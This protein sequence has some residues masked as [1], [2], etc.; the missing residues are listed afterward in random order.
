MAEQHGFGPLDAE[1]LAAY[2]DGRLAPEERAR[3][4]S[5]LA[6]SS[7]AYEWLV[8]V[9]RAAAH[10]EAERADEGSGNAARPGADVP[11]ATGGPAGPS[12]AGTAAGP[13][14]HPPRVLPFYRR[15]GF[16]AGV[17]TTMAAAAALVVALDVTPDWWRR[18]VTPERSGL[19]VLVAAVGDERYVES[20]FTGG[21]KYGPLRSATRGSGDG[22]TPNLALMAAAGEL[23]QESRSRPTVEN[24]HAW[25]VAQVLLGYYDEGLRALNL[26]LADAPESPAVMADLAAAHIARGDALSTARDYPRALAAAEQALARRPDLAEAAFNRALALERLGL[27]REALEAWQQVIAISTGAGD[28]EEWTAEARRRVDT[29]KRSLDEARSLPGF[30]SLEDTTEAS[31]RTLAEED[32]QRAREFVEIHVLSAWGHALLERRRA[33]ADRFLALARV[34]A[35]PIGA[36]GN[37]S[38]PEAVALIEGS[39]PAARAT[40]ARAHVRFGESLRLY[41]GEQAG[42]TLDGF[43]ESRLLFERA[44]SPYRSW[45]AVQEMAVYYLRGGLAAATGAADRLRASPD[46]AKYPEIDARLS[47]AQGLFAANGGRLQEALQH[48]EHAAGLY[49]TLGERENGVFLKTLTAE[50]LDFVGDEGQAWRYRVEA[51]REALPARNPRRPHTTWVNAAIAAIRQGTPEVA[52]HLQDEAVALAEVHRQP[53]LTFEAHLYRAR[54]GVAAGNTAMALEDLRIA[55][56]LLPSLPAAF[57]PRMKTEVLVTHGTLPGQTADTLSRTAAAWLAE[58]GAVVRVPTLMQSAAAAR[59]ARGDM[60]G[61]LQD[62]SQAIDAATDQVPRAVESLRWAYADT[63]WP[64]FRQAAILRMATGDIT[65]ALGV[66]EMG[67]MRLPGGAPDPAALVRVPPGVVAVRFLVG[68]TRS[69]AVILAGDGQRAVPLD[70]GLT[71]VERD[72]QRFRLLAAARSDRATID[73]VLADL[74][75]RWVSPWVD[76]VPEGATLAVIPDGPMYHVP[77]AALRLATGRYLAQRNPVEVWSDLSARLAA[78]APGAPTG[79][80]TVGLSR[81]EHTGL[82]SLKPLPG[83]TDEAIS[84]GLQHRETALVGSQATPAAVQQRLAGARVAHFATH[85]LANPEYPNLSW[86]ALAPDEAHPRGLWFAGEIRQQDLH[87]TELVYLSACDG[88]AGQLSRA[89]GAASLARAF[90]DAGVGTVIASGWTLDDQVASRISRV[91]Y[92]EYTATGNATSSLNAAQRALID[93]GDAVSPLVWSAMQVFTR[94]RDTRPTS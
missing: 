22:P 32:A 6:A 63:L 86:I 60:E 38:L 5:E 52:V 77:F 51:L 76:L 18:L 82:E 45:A 93:E 64:L 25:G 67:V 31:L 79:T 87:D 30:P 81:F 40:L 24:L 78:R 14:D 19:E 28:H 33:D 1:T 75:A 46:V 92:S 89:E 44:G 7:E 65:G 41:E 61:A 35:E 20:R 3:V 42:T 66:A 49:S 80:L 21:F 73:T 34:A 12:D 58:T 53:T 90:L 74:G 94:N 10:T 37:R 36:R 83:A 68:D 17:V 43:T 8:S 15:R 85:A 13:S 4:E 2:L 57:Q 39:A 27:R 50:V 88:S 91:F 56:D 72:V 47:W 29:L 26:A 16:I 84:I 62:L 23:Q 71:A 70:V 9:L 59:L 54:A 11:E 55:E 48:Y 69:F